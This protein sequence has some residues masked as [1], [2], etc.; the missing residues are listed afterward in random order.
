MLEHA[1]VRLRGRSARALRLVAGCDDDLGEDP[2]IA[3]AVAPSTGTVE[4]DDAAEGADRVTG[5]R[6]A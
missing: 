3:S 2:T 1:E 4:R 6:A 5:E